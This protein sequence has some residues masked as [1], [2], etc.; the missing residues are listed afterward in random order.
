ML[1]CPQAREDGY[2]ACPDNKVM[3]ATAKGLATIFDDPQPPAFRPIVR[4]KL[5]Q[6]NNTMNDAVDRL[7]ELIGCH[8]VE[9]QNRCF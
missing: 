4:S 1:N 8:I 2:A 7:V 3:I 6:V 5:L 9:Q